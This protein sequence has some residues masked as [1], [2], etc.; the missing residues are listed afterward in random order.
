MRNWR[1]FHGQSVPKKTVQSM[2]TKHNPVTLPINLYAVGPPD[3]QPLDLTKFGDHHS[4]QHMP[5]KQVTEFFVHVQS[6]SLRMTKVALKS[7]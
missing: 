4:V 2:A 3:V 1:A 6:D 7:P 5:Q